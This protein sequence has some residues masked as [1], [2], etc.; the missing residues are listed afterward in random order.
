LSQSF[1]GVVIGEAYKIPV[2]NFRHIPGRPTGVVQF[3]TDAECTTDP[4]IFEFYKA[5]GVPSFPT[6]AQRRDT[7]SNW[8]EIIDAIDREWKPVNPE[9]QPLVNAF[10]LPLA[11]DPLKES[12]S[13]FD[14]ISQIKF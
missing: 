12:C 3:S 14:H 4:R 8:G 2:M 10:P 1:H 5:A 13:N 11:Y 9:L 6:Y 7:A